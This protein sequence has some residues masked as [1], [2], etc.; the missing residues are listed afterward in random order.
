MASPPQG[1]RL[2]MNHQRNEYI[3]GRSWSFIPTSQS[4]GPSR[5]YVTS[6]FRVAFFGPLSR[7]LSFHNMMDAVTQ[8]GQASYPHG[9]TFEASRRTVFHMAFFKHTTIPKALRLQKTFLYSSIPSSTPIINKE[10]A[11]NTTVFVTSR[12]NGTKE[13]KYWNESRV[14]ISQ[15]EGVVQPKGQDSTFVKSKPNPRKSN[16]NLWTTELIL[17]HWLRMFRLFGNLFALG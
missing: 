13:G 7:G 8:Q 3:W 1:R 11:Q 14:N 4:T 5:N 10:K 15:H 9:D 16:F 17:V 12:L 6:V 2:R